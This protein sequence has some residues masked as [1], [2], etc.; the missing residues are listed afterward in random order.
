MYLYDIYNN[1]DMEVYKDGFD[2]IYI[3]EKIEFYV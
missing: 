2:K 1:L 3:K